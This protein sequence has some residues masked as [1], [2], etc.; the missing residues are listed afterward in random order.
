MSKKNKIEKN[1]E[2]LKMQKIKTL[3]VK[4]TSVGEHSVI[5]DFFF[6]RSLTKFDTDLSVGKFFFSPKS[7]QNP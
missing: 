5:V 1:V 3:K 7:E 2:D 4:S 6:R